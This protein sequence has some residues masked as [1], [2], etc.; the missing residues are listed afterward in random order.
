LAM[1]RAS[2]F[3]VRSGSRWNGIRVGG[4]KSFWCALLLGPWR[5]LVLGLD[6]MSVSTAIV[7]LLSGLLVN[8][9]GLQCQ[10]TSTGRAYSWERSLDGTA[11]AVVARKVKF[12][13]SNLSTDAVSSPGGMV[14]RS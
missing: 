5:D 8:C 12:P 4:S 2:A 9:G 10:S 3:G 6:N 7:P 11:H 13:S 1:D 14:S